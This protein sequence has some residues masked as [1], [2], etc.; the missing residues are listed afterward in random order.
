VGVGAA[1]RERFNLLQAFEDAVAWRSG[2]LTEPCPDCEPGESGKR[3]DDHAGDAALVAQYRER[4]AEVS[5]A[6]GARTAG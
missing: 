4:H 2:R 6:I 5:A 3:C 1:D